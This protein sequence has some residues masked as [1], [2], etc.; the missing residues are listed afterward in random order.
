MLD[1]ACKTKI[2][3]LLPM[4]TTDKPGE[5]LNAVSAINRVLKSHNSNM[6]ELTAVLT[7][8]PTN[9]RISPM[10]E[11]IYKRR[12]LSLELEMERL[13]NSNLSLSNENAKLKARVNK[14]EAYITKMYCWTVMLVLVAMYSFLKG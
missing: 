14:S 9:N 10:D 11:Y 1:Q 8:T 12:I 4:L 7:Q 6:H 5:L 13:K 3:K 2:G